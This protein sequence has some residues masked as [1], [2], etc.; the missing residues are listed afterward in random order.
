MG[1]VVW[2]EKY[3]KRKSWI[4]S[5]KYNFNTLYLPPLGEVY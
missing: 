2:M 4:S 1:G 3:F 5:K